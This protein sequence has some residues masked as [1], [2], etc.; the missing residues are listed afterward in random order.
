MIYMHASYMAHAQKIKEIVTL[1]IFIKPIFIWVRLASE[2][3]MAAGGWSNRDL[4][5]RGNH[6]P[7][8]TK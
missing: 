3:V 6:S 2:I 1:N 8:S 5:L 7:R 4:V